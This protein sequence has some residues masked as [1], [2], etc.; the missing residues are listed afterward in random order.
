MPKSP[1]ISDGDSIRTT[2]TKA[3]KREVNPLVALVLGAKFP[4]VPSSK[5]GGEVR[6]TKNT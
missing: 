5:N 1:E 2:F 3:Y 4:L 6:H